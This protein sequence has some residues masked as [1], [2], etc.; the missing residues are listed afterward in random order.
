MAL[1]F[2]QLKQVFRRLAKAPLFTAITLITLAVGIGANT[3]VFSVVN[4]VLLK[5]L[6]YPQADQ[7]IGV[8][9][10]APGV[11]LPEIDMGAFM[12]FT[13]RDQS[14]TF[15]DIGCYRSD[16]LSITGSGQ[17]EHVEG[18]DMTDGALGILGAKPMLGRL[19][20]RQDDQPNAAKTVIL[21]YGY[22]QRR[23]GGSN[24]VIGRSMTIDGSAHEIIG[25]LPR[26][27]HFLDNDE[28][29]VFLPMQLD[30]S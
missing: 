3:V 18:M 6:S 29:A 4:A 5:P 2:D 22:W 28:A 17:P 9:H 25:V 20:N 23:F 27:F 19:F 15:Q 26:G 24:S 14:T 30:R 13:Y 7:L 16:S 1:F 21:S 10:S 12:Y 11:N 8:W